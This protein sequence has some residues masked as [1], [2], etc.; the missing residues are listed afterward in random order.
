[1]PYSPINHETIHTAVDPLTKVQYGVAE[2]KLRYGLRLG[3]DSIKELTDLPDSEGDGVSLFQPNYAVT[4]QELSGSVRKLAAHTLIRSESFVVPF[5]SDPQQVEAFMYGRSVEKVY[6]GS[7]TLTEPRVLR[8]RIQKVTRYFI[9]SN[10]GQ[11]I[12]PID[13]GIEVYLNGGLLSPEHAE[14]MLV[15][16]DETQHHMANIH[17]NENDYIDSFIRSVQAG[18]QTQQD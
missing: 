6:F 8:R 2:M 3:E 5:E 7:I 16:L 13:D 14:G 1:M 4:T 9:R 10:P 11:L 17:R 12:P 15:M 18:E